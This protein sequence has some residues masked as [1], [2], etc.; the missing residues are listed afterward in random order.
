MGLFGGSTTK[1]SQSS[2]QYGA[3]GG[4][5]VIGE[6]A[7]YIQEFPDTVA[8]FAEKALDLAG[9]GIA[10]SQAAIS[11]LS[12]VAER[13]KTPL[14]EWLPLVAVGV[15]GAAFIAFVIYRG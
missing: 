4:G 2:T 12:T 13:E 9:S 10:Q 15:A 1:T 8:S 3:E 5:I 6:G 7:S 11:S 14:A